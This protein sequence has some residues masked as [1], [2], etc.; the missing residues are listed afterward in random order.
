MGAGGS[1]F[2]TL[3]FE[4]SFVGDTANGPELIGLFKK[5]Y[6][7]VP[8]NY[9]ISLT[10]GEPVELLDIDGETG[11]FG[12]FILAGTPEEGWMNSFT[13]Y[14]VLINGEEVLR[15]ETLYYSFPEAYLIV[16]GDRR[17]VV[18]ITDQSSDDTYTYIY[19]IKDG[20]LVGDPEKYDSNDFSYIRVNYGDGEWDFNVTAKTIYDPMSIRCTF[21]HD[22][23]G[24]NILSGTFA[25]DP[26]ER[27]FKSTSRYY[28]FDSNHTLT[29]KKA[30]KAGM[31]EPDLMFNGDE[32]VTGEMDM[33]VELNEGDTIHLEKATDDMQVFF[34]AANGEWGTFKLDPSLDPEFRFSDTINGEKINEIFDGIIYAD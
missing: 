26:D 32:N 34:S 28:D 15:S 11:S 9:M 16:M 14:Y 10:M 30:F 13:D 3:S 12:T 22:I 24:T 18:L 20:E 8:E 6:R 2:A 31:I 5:K 4:E 27:L 17:F 33:E 21:R 7:T 25:L 29:L 23:I 1:F 19:E